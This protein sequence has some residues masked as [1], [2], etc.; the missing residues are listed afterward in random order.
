MCVCVEFLWASYDHLGFVK[1]LEF[2]GG[3]GEETGPEGEQ[4]FRQCSPAG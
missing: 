2:G 3:G 4:Y 1:D